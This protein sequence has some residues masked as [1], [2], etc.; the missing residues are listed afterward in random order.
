MNGDV[1]FCY[2]GPGLGS[3]YPGAKGDE[4]MSR[5]L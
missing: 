3:V 1:H 2:K 4:A 5:D